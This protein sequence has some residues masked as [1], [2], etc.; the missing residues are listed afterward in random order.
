MITIGMTGNWMTSMIIKIPEE[1]ADRDVEMNLVHTLFR[2]GLI[3]GD[4]Y[5]VMQTRIRFRRLL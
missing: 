4:W 5:Y 3:K 1:D 2:L